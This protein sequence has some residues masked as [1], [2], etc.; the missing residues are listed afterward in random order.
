MAR[1][2]FHLYATWNIPAWPICPADQNCMWALYKSN[3]TAH[4]KAALS[5][6]MSSCG[7]HGRGRSVAC[8]HWL[9]DRAWKRLVTQPAIVETETGFRQA[10]FGPTK[11]RFCT[12]C[13]DSR[14]VGSCTISTER[15]HR[16]LGYGTVMDEL[17]H[18]SHANL[19]F[20]PMIFGWMS[21]SDMVWNTV[22]VER[23]LDPWFDWPVVACRPRSS[24]T[25]QAQISRSWAISRDK[26]RSNRHRE[27]LGVGT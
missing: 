1:Q 22:R 24:K 13:N 4:P 6:G 15:Y 9:I 19:E 2:R 5:E 16:L 10:K 21:W 17:H 27:L 23:I 3:L 25:S 8:V 7:D 12:Y 11:Y 18:R 26:E 14:C 20:P